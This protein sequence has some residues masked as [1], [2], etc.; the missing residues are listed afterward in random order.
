MRSIIINL[1]LYEAA[2]VACV[3][4]AAY[5]YPWLGIGVCAIAV[6]AHLARTDDMPGELVLIGSIVLAG[7]LFDSLLAQ[8]GW[9]SYQQHFPSTS[10]AP[11][12]IVG[13]WAAFATIVRTSLKW[14]SGRT[15]LAAV[16]GVLG[17]PLAYF[18]GA[19]FGAIDIVDVVPATV[20]LGIGW[21]LLMIVLSRPQLMTRDMVLA[22]V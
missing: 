4:G 21:A 19:R 17:G 8:S 16:L 5:G 15:L 1:A 11:L 10:W 6:G 2:W 14:M 22:G 18:A 7:G 3:F 20:A 13:L 12:W 9:I